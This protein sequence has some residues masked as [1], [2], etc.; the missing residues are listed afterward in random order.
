M[1]ACPYPK[2]PSKQAAVAD[3]WKKEVDRLQA[4][5]L[6][7][8]SRLIAFAAEDDAEKQEKKMSTTMD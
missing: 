6:H 3:D 4:G 1:Q 7:V 8:M 2:C 5:W